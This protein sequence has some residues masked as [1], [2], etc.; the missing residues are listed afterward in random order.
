[1]LSALVTS[2]VRR[3]MLFFLFMEPKS[4]FYVRQLA[5]LA[6]EPTNAIRRELEILRKAG[7]LLSRPKGNLKYYQA[8]EKCPIY[9]ELKLMVMKTEGLGSAL[10]SALSRQNKIMFAFVYGSSASGAERENSDIDLMVVGNI[11]IDELNRVLF[12]L[13]KI[14]GRE[15][16]YAVYPPR[17]FLSKRNS[18]FIKNISL[19]RKIMLVGSED[20]LNLWLK[21]PQ[22]QSNFDKF[23]LRRK[24]SITR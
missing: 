17:E 15:I 11:S 6:D 22:S 10:R 23:G 9:E 8:N 16:N 1:M 13:Q 19:G 3:K 21:K 5:R 4:E 14:L 7:I 18:G 20:I 2:R 12:P 24:I